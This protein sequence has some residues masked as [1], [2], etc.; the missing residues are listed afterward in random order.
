[1]PAVMETTLHR[2]L[3]QFYAPEGAP[4]EVTLGEFRIDAVR[5]GELIEIQ[6]ASLGALRDKTRKLLATHAVRIVKPLAVNR[7]IVLREKGTA[8]DGRGRLSPRHEGWLHLFDDLVHFVTVFPHPR[9]TLDILLT[10]QLEVR[11][12]HANRRRWGRNYQVCDRA[13][14]AVI[15]CRS[16][17][18]TAD[19]I[20]LLPPELPAEFTTADL[21]RTGAIPRWLAQRAAYCLRQTKAA[22]VAGKQG[23]AW[24]YRLVDI[25]AA[26]SRN[27]RSSTRKTPRNKT[28]NTALGERVNNQGD[29]SGAENQRQPKQLAPHRKRR[30]G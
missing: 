18:T 27:R 12:P 21:A 30:T 11:K 13:L 23:N 20:A 26:P 1:M 8:A 9:L 10:E 6:A 14:T 25:E 22:E 19:L 7:R 29:Q 17:C 5:N 24:V 2:Q 15:E 3:K 16:L 28:P 4:Q